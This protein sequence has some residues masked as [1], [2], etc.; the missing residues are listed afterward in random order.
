LRSALVRPRRIKALAGGDKPPPLRTGLYLK[1]AA[2]FIPARI[3]WVAVKKKEVE[4]VRNW[5]VETVGKSRR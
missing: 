3:G 2:G 5:A 1:V 4:K